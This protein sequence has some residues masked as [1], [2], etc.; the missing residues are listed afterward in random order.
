M[1]ISFLFPG[2]NAIILDNPFKFF[3]HMR[4]FKQFDTLRVFDLV[5]AERSFTRAAETLHMTK[6]AVSYQIKRLEQELGFRVFN[7]QYGGV[8]LTPKGRRLWHVSQ[9]NFQQLER[10]IT[11]LKGIDDL[12]ITIGMSTYFASRW[13]SPRLMRFTSAHPDVGLRLQPAAGIIDLE[14]ERVDMAIRWGDG[15]WN[16]MKIEP[17][18]KCPA[19]ATAGD[20]IATEIQTAGLAASLENFTLL[21]DT[22][23]STAWR[24]WHHTAGIPYQ[25]KPDELVIPDPNVRVQAVIDGQGIALNDSLVGREIAEGL[26]LKISEVE[27]EDYGYFLAYRQDSMANQALRDF[28]DWILSESELD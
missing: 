15:S 13:L 7:R 24:D 22:E 20:A 26:L 23:G 14:K 10:E 2:N 25:E 8:S 4:R 18:F 11:R 17:L 9:V 27:L 5:A 12:G 21:H 19:I 3:K 16:D 1:M 28:K 6:G